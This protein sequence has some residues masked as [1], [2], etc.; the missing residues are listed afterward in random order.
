MSV[1]IREY[2][3][4]DHDR[5]CEIFRQGLLDQIGKAFGRVLLGKE[6]RILVQY[7]VIVALF[8]LYSPT[9]WIT[10]LGIAWSLGV[11]SVSTFWCFYFYQRCE[12]VALHHKI[13]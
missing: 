1:Q 7:S 13:T 12:N 11:F 10:L 4:G 6:P 9:A 3:P 2:V 8:I 5:V